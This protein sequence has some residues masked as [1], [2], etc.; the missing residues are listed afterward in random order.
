V[1]APAPLVAAPA[2]DRSAQPGHTLPLPTLR[3]PPKQAAWKLPAVI[4]TVVLSIAALVL[5]LMAFRR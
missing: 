2:G 1:S 5:A 4:V 3:R